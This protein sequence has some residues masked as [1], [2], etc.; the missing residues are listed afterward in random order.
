MKKTLRKVVSVL[1]LSLILAA[2]GGGGG[3][4]GASTPSQT[5]PQGTLDTVIQA[6]KTNDNATIAASF[7]PLAQQKYQPYLSDLSKMREFGESLSKAEQIDFT[8]NLAVYK[9]TF[10]KNGT[11]LNYFIFMVKDEKGIWKF[12]TF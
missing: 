10:N 5:S 12:D 2:C 11:T 8:D 4:G 6:A 1:F 3:G 9:S 7:T